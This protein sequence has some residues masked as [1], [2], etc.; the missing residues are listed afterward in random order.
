MRN[1]LIFLVLIIL[2][3]VS[4][5]FLK[6]L[7]G[8]Q[9]PFSTG[10]QKETARKDEA[11]FIFAK[12]LE[13]PWGIQFLPGSIL[14]TERPGKLWMIDVNGGKPI[15]IAQI[16]QVKAIGEG[17]REWKLI[18]KKI[19][20]DKIPGAPNHNGGRIKFGPDG[21]LYNQNFFFNQFPF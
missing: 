19:L 15:L 16:S 8:G 13:V 11:L 20:V 14:F 5:N 10:T 7:N 4:F 18:E 12:N 2:I 17:G 1:A 21:M 6:V 9:N 3:L